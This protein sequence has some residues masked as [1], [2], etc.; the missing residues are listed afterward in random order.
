MTHQVQ[1]FVG[2][3]GVRPERPD[4]QG[5]EGCSFPYWAMIDPGR[6][7]RIC[8]N[9]IESGVPAGETK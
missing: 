3:V 6:D 1:T 4:P 8:G 5:D 9:P 7:I 2:K